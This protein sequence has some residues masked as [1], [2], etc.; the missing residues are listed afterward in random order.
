MLHA[1]SVLH[2]LRLSVLLSLVPSAPWDRAFLWTRA[3]PNFLFCIARN[4]LNPRDS[5]CSTRPHHA[6][7]C[8]PRMV[9]SSPKDCPLDLSYLDVCFHYRSDGLLDAFSPLRAT[10]RAGLV[11][12]GSVEV[13]SLDARKV[14]NMALHPGGG[15]RGENVNRYN[16]PTRHG[17]RRLG[18]EQG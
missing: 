1:G 5:D 15:L 9:R 10:I 8:A 3:N 18:V 2:I 17:R 6:L 7:S 14:P 11:L 13:D 4:T 12:F 16:P